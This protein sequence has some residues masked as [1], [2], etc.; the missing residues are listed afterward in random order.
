MITRSA[1]LLPL[2]ILSFFYYP[3]VQ[4]QNN[5]VKKNIGYYSGYQKTIGGQELKYH[6]FSPFATMSLLTRCTDGNMSIRWQTDSVGKVPK[7]ITHLSFCWM[8]GFSSGTSHG[9]RSFN[10]KIDGQPVGRLFTRKDGDNIEWKAIGNGKDYNLQFHLISNDAVKDCFGYMTLEV[11]AGMK[12][13]GA[14]E[15]EVTGTADSSNDWFMIFTRDLGPRITASVAPAIV[16]KNDVRYREVALY[17]ETPY[18]KAAADIFINGEKAGTV[19]VGYSETPS[20]GETT[21][22]IFL[23]PYSETAKSV[24]VQ[25][26]LPQI[27]L[28]QTVAV[29][30]AHISEVYLLPHSH[31]DIGYTDVQ[32]NILKFQIGNLQEALTLIEETRDFPEGSRYKWNSEINWSLEAFLQQASPEMRDRMIQEINN[33]NIGINGLFTNPLTGIAKAE[34]LMR[35]TE[36]CRKLHNEYGITFKSTMITDIPGLSWSMVP[37]LYSAGIRYLSEGPNVFDRIGWSTVA[38]GDR[39]FYWLSPSG[40]EKILVWVCGKGYSM[41]HSYST[42][43]EFKTFPLKLFSYVNELDS[44]GYPYDMIQVRCAL[45]SD[46]GPNDPTLSRYVAAW[47]ARYEYPKLVIAT[48]DELFTTFEKKYGDRIPSYSGDFTPYWEDGA[49]SSATELGINR[50]YSEKCLQLEMAYSILNPALYNNAQFYEMWKNIALFTEHTWGAFNSTTDPDNPFVTDQ[51]KHKVQY[52]TNE[53]S[54][55]YLLSRPLFGQSPSKYIE[56]INTTGCSRSEVVIMNLPV[57]MSDAI[58]L[59]SKGKEVTSQLL[60]GNRIAFLATGI[61]AFGSRSFTIKSRK[62]SRTVS[63]REG[64]MLDTPSL[65]LRIDAGSGAV[66]SLTEKAT[67]RELCGFGN[68]NAYLYIE[69]LSPES[70]TGTTLLKSEIVSAGPLVYQMK[71]SMNAPGASSLETMYTMLSTDTALRIVNTLDKTSVR[72]KEAAYFCFPFN[73]KNPVNRFDGGWSDYQPGKNQLQGS[74]MDFFYAMRWADVSSD[75]NGITL[76]VDEAPLLETGSITDESEHNIGPAGWKNSTVPSPVLYSYVLNNYWHTNFKADQS[77]KMDFS[78]MLIPH[79]SFDRAETYRRSIGYHQPLLVR[80]T[81]APAESAS[82][83]SVSDKAIIVTSIKPTDDNK[84]FMIRMFN[85]SGSSR[86]FSIEWLRMQPEVIYVS[87]TMEERLV[88]F[89]NVYTLPPSGILTIRVEK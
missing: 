36:T 20:N 12:K 84:G 77:G 57:L 23:I 39:P 3:L 86:E 14:F 35:I 47:N 71:V 64:L 33:G 16:K 68:I 28:Q 72:N 74:C 61:P 58:I 69:G 34:E 49:L 7:E 75:T 52:I 55:Y 48:T 79:N 87:N 70:V 66:K 46:N 41:F 40:Q 26:H 37:A 13:Q 17:I 78:Y 24:N 63:Q 6:S 67:N 43:A 80:F 2:L 25:V 59:N 65:Y 38:H 5:T 83:F 11:P 30:A 22:H 1:L 4:A 51:W 53:D 42:I 44:A 8:V 45:Y 31:N 27:E 60:S 85:A 89:N 62:K 88:T 54:L 9:D 19:P 32:P 56:V 50:K 21:P 82:L 29:P 10:V 18:A 15:I 73:E 76:V 81:E